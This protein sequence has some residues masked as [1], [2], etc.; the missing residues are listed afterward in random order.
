MART[1]PL[2]RQWARELRRTPTPQERTLWTYL[3]GNQMDGW[4]FVRQ[5]VLRGWIVDFAC[6][7]AKVVVEV[8]GPY[9]LSRKVEDARRDRVMTD[10]G[11]T[12][13]RFTNSQV[14]A[15]PQGVAKAI[16]RVL[17]ERLVTT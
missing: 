17:D 16:Q 7:R 8:D 13:L 9:H 2:K 3:S 15:N 6:R 1:K 12:V 4:H 5:H 11:W 14:D 10:L